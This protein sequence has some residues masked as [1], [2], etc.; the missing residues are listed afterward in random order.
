MNKRVEDYLTHQVATRPDALAFEDNTGV[1]VTYAELDAAADDIGARLTGSPAEQRAVQWAAEELRKDGFDAVTLE[2][3]MAPHW[4]RGHERV[5]DAESGR[6]LSV[7]SLGN[8]AGTPDGP[9]TAPVLIVR[10]WD[11]LSAR[12][13][14]VPGHIVLFNAHGG[15]APLSL[16][17][18]DGDTGTD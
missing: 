17:V 1:A 16:V 13:D 5:R 10:D 9:L 6:R 12:A 3:V 15:S 14:E 4:V 11:E 18:V 8:S 2:P 7:L